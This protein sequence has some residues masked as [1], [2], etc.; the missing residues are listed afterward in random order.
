MKK[1]KGGG[2]KNTGTLQ[3]LGHKHQGKR[4]PIVYG[5]AALNLH[6]LP[7]DCANQI[8]SLF[9]EPIARRI[10]KANAQIRSTKRILDMEDAAGLLFLAQDG[11]YSINPATV[12]DL[13]A[14]CLKGGNFRSI[15]HIIHF[16]AN[17]PASRPNDSLGYMFWTHARRDENGPEL[18]HELFTSLSDAWRN[19]LEA[20]IGT[21]MINPGQ[22]PE[23][24]TLRFPKSR[25]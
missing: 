20:A 11:D 8:I 14:R 4:V 7:T 12:F 10:R 2:C 21:T 19:E 15:D 18:P 6:S 17:L 16:N 22:P 1:S 3:G 13:A 23:L 24:D 25:R 9:R 5:R